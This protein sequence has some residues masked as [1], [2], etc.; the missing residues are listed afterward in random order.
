MNEQGSGVGN[1]VRQHQSPTVT[2]REGLLCVGLN[3]SDFQHELQT[4][5]P[6]GLNSKQPDVSKLSKDVGREGNVTAEP[7]SL[8][9]PHSDWNIC[10][11][12]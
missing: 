8:C 10:W 12:I 3:A 7:S 5:R 2:L 4:V 11:E 1:E 6:Q 9:V